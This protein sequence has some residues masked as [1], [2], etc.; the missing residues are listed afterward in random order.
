MKRLSLLIL[1][2]AFWTIAFGQESKDYLSSKRIQQLEDSETNSWKLQ[3]YAVLFSKIENYKASLAAQNLYLE[4][5]KAAMNIPEKPKADS[6]YFKSFKPQKAIDVIAKAAKNYKV[7][8]TNEAHYQPQ[9]RIF[10]Y[11]LLDTLYKEDFRYLCVEDLSKDDTVYKSK[12][13]KELNA[14]KY[15]IRTTGFYMD[16]PQYGNLVRHALKLGYT[17]VPY[18]Y[19]ASEIKDPEQRIWSRENGQ[20]KNI[21]QILQKDPNAKILVHCGYGH[22][23]E[24]II[25]DS[26]GQMGAML[27]LHYGIDPLTID[28]QVMLEENNDSY[29]RLTNAK[30]PSVYVSGNHFFNDSTATHKVDMVV[31]FPRTQ[32]ING[33]PDWLVYDKNRKYYFANLQKY[34]AIYPV[35]IFAFHKEED[36]TVS[37]P[38]DIIEMKNPNDKVALV[39]DKGQYTLRIKDSEGEIYQQTVQVK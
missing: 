19:Y 7:V 20:A 16:E 24:N 1:A 14:R 12:E 26:V 5:N 6:V 21:A 33:R 13:D 35:M 39:L 11:L 37:I 9:N 10:T 17:L 8:I 38:A 18:E 2:I 22:L 36:I 29:Y 31:F 28:Q 30:Q 27:K 15:P 32:Y 3:D 25:R 23:N 4:K 34:K